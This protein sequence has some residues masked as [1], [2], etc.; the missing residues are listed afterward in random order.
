[1][2]TNDQ[3]RLRSEYAV[4][5]WRAARALF[6]VALLAMIASVAPSRQASAAPSGLVAAYAFDEGSGTT[7]A[8]ASGNGHTGAIANATWA[9]AGE[10]GKALQFNGTSAIVTIPD[11]ADLHLS[12]AMTL[13]AW[14]NP[15]TVNAFW[16]DVVY[17]G[18]DNY[19]LEATSQPTSHPV[20]G[21]VAGGS[22]GEAY[23]TANLPTN[24]WSFLTATYD[25]ANVRFYLN[26][27][28]VATTAH[29]GTIASSTNPLTIGGDNI[30]GQNFAGLIDNVRVYNVALTTAQI[31]TDQTTPV[32][33]AG[34]DTQPPTQPGTLTATA[35]SAGE[36]DL[37]W[38]ASNDNVGVTGY[39]VERCLGASCTTFAQIATPTTTTY[40]D[41]S[42]TA[43][44]SY[45]YRVR[46]TDAAGNLSPYTNTANATTPTPDT[47]PP[48]QPGTLTATAISAG[49]VDLAWGASND[50]VGVTG[51]QVERCLGASC[52]TFAQIATPTTTTY[53]DTSV[54]A[55]NSY[56]YRVRATDAAGNLSPYTN[57][58]NA[59]TPAA[60]VGFGGGVCVR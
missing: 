2:G 3:G 50:N 45:S 38:G 26:G 36:V 58:A 57:T 18:N 31:Q 48:T 16:R 5:A 43:S 35:I 25:G 27:T 11:A 15:S 44:N 10:Y 9:T 49:E 60:A 20:A 7:V 1:M 59:T 46:A 8:D 29:T 55:S 56:S 53:K 4:R 51:Y 30:Y 24:T 6:L 40:K 54:T 17:K 37:A 19:Y 32:T 34:P 13:E 12:T 14:V 21:T 47:Q 52:T 41:T 23:G 39:Q 33:P 22:Y 42:V 28:L